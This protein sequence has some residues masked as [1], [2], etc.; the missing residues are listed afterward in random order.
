MSTKS[1]FPKTA[2]LA[3]APWRI[4]RT[5]KAQDGGA[6]DQ[7]TPYGYF[8]RNRRST[9]FAFMN[10]GKSAQAHKGLTPVGVDTLQAL[11]NRLA[12]AEPPEVVW[13]PRQPEGVATELCPEVTKALTLQKLKQAQKSARLSAFVCLF[14][15]IIWLI[16]DTPSSFLVFFLLFGLIPLS[17]ELFKLQ[18]FRRQPLR[19]VRRNRETWLFQHWLNQK[20][21]LATYALGL[22]LGTVAAIH[23]FHVGLS[24]GVE[25]AGL[26]PLAIADGEIWRL[27]S[28]PPH[29]RQHPPRHLQYHSAP[30]PSPYRDHR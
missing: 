12:D 26:E 6:N 7:N 13:T 23:F 27:F 10:R 8:Y 15:L 4:G 20:K 5:P 22:A 3:V 21:P 25:A 2:S 14:F 16:P 9:T 17:I 11:R 19:Q 30:W 29:P 28:G 1:R 24:P 18:A